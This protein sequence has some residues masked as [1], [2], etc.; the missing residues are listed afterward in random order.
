MKKLIY[1]LSQENFLL[2]QPVIV[3]KLINYKY[4]DFKTIEITVVECSDQIQFNYN[5]ILPYKEIYVA[6]D[7]FF[8]GA[9]SH[10]IFESAIWIPHIRSLN[11]QLPSV[12]KFL[13]SEPRKFKESFLDST[14]F[15][16]S[17]QASPENYTILMPPITTINLNYYTL[18][19]KKLLINFH[20]FLKGLA[21]DPS[22]NVKAVLLPRGK[23][24]NFTPNDRFVD[25]NQIE[26]FFKDKSPNL[27]IFNSDESPN[28]LHQ[29]DLIRRAELILVPD[30]AAL[31]F[32]G[33]LA[34]NS[35]LLVFNS[36]LVRSQIRIYE[37]G[38]EILNIIKNNNNNIIYVNSI[39]GQFRLSEIM[40]WLNNLYIS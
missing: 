13:L 24:E 29:I 36:E 16:Y 30:G 2:G 9:F 33:F 40:P 20:Y 26:E 7:T 15:G 10:W 4:L 1:R 37:K 35:T 23:A 34:Q 28:L 38:L 11:G 21:P 19:Y 27:V 22:K 18:A 25:T 5:K 6:A 14:G 8:N 31:V 39:E 3:Q 17:Y 32:N 12:P